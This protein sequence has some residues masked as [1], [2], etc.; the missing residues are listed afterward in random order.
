[1]AFRAS[2]ERTRRRKPIAEGRQLIPNAGLEEW[3]RKELDRQI[4]EMVADYKK[5]LGYAFRKKP[6]V[7]YYAEDASPTSIMTRSL[8]RLR[9]KWEDVFERFSKRTAENFAAKG[10]DYSKFSS[11]HSLKSLGLDNPKDPKASIISEAVKASIQENVALIK[12]IQQDFAQDIEG[13]VYRSLASNDPEQGTNFVMKELIERG[14][15][16]KRRAHTIARDQN[17][18]LYA[19]LNKARMEANG[20]EKFEWV[21]SSAGKVPRQSHIERQYQDVGYGLGIFRFDSP[22]LYQGPKNDRGIPGESINCRCRAR[23]VLD[24]SILD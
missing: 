18:K 9:T 17:S 15:M 3:Y 4:R 19:N 16:T 20:V 23:P 12:N 6:V 10:D 1:M 22:E 24:L 2:K 13:N 8:R 21:H 5:E 14:E 11:K 7:K